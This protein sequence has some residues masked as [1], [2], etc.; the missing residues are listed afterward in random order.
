MCAHRRP[1]SLADAIEASGWPKPSVHRMLGRVESRGLLEREPLLYPGAPP[2]APPQRALTRHTATTLADRIAREAELEQI[3]RQGYAA[4]ACAR[5]PRRWDGP[6]H[7]HF[8][9]S[10]ADHTDH[11]P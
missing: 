5:P 6:G 9:L 3:V 1:F 10:F 8:S 11:S 7:Q 4:D 2:V